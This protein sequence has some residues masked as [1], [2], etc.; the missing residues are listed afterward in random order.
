MRDRK[1]F[2]PQREAQDVTFMQIIGNIFGALAFVAMLAAIVAFVATMLASAVKDR[3]AGSTPPS[4]Q[5]E[6]PA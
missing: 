2:V 1:T 6:G 5:S 4:V 3:Q